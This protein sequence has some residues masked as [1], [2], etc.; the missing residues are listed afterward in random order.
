MGP[1]EMR[2]LLVSGV[3][4]TGHAIPLNTRGCGSQY[5][6]RCS[7]GVLRDVEA[8]AV[9]EKYAGE[10]GSQNVFR[11]EYSAGMLGMPALTLGV[12]DARC[13]PNASST[14]TPPAE[15]GFGADN[16]LTTACKNASGRWR[17]SSTQLSRSRLGSIGK[18]TV[19]GARTAMGGAEIEPHWDGSTNG[20][21]R[22]TGQLLQ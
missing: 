3:V 1:D 15:T 9:R 17:A 20:G 18:L 6:K 4:Q 8:E 21:Y 10:E 2:P 16:A 11:M 22:D 19:G 5:R 13:A 14:L 12:N 7:E